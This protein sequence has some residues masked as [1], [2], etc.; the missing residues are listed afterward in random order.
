MKNKRKLILMVGLSTSALLI[1]SIAAVGLLKPA[2]VDIFSKA[3]DIYSCDLPSGY[4]EISDLMDYIYENATDSEIDN[5]YTIRGTITRRHD[6]FAFLQRVNQTTGYTDAIR[7]SGLN[8]LEINLKEGS[9]I[10]IQG[11]K[12]TLSYNTPTLY[13]SESGDTT[14]NVAF[15]TNPWGYEPKVY[16]GLNDYFSRGLASDTYNDNEEYAFSRYIK[17][18]G[19][20]PSFFED[21]ESY[22]IGDETYYIGGVLDPIYT[23]SL[24]NFAIKDNVGVS[25]KMS[26]A[27]SE[28]KLI[29][30]T[31][32][33]YHHSDYYLVLMQSSDDIT[34]SDKT[35]YDENVI[36]TR[37]S[38]K[39]IFG[40]ADSS[41][42]SFPSYLLKNKGDVPYVDFA[43][44]F[45]YRCAVFYSDYEY[46]VLDKYYLE[47]DYVV[48]SNQNSLG[49][50]HIDCN[51]D[52]ITVY[53]YSGYL[54]M[55]LYRLD[56]GSPYLDDR[57]DLAWCYPNEKSAGINH[58]DRIKTFDLG[59]FGLDIVMDKFGNAFVPITV[60]SNIFLTN[61]GYSFSFNGSNLYYVYRLLNDSDLLNLYWADSPFND[62]NRSEE[63]SAFTY[64]D[65]CFTLK[66]CYGLF[67]ERYPDG[68]P[69]ELIQS[70]GLKD[71]LTSTN[72]DELEEGLLKLT[73][74]WIFEGHAGYSALSPLTHSEDF[75]MEVINQIY[76]EALATNSRYNQLMETN[77]EL[78]SYRDEFGKQ[79]GLE[80]SGDTAIIRFDGFV[81]YDNGDTNTIDVDSYTY[82]QIHDMGS[83]LLFKKAFKEIGENPDID[84]VIIDLSL[85]GG[86]HIAV[87]PWLLAYLT[88]DV[89][90]AFRNITYGEETDLH[91][92]VDLN[93]DGVYDEL[94]TYKGKYNYYC[95][96]SR[97]SFSCGNWLPTVIH[98]KG[99]A[100]MIG[101]RSGGGIC[102]VSN[103]S[104]AVGTVFR[105][106]SLNQMGVYDGNNF[107][108]YED[109]SEVDYQIDR[110][111]FYDTAYLINFIHNLSN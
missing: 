95:L 110:Q 83:E 18:N 72:N 70:L 87:V 81:K 33:M 90:V 29:N 73:G 104:S 66:Y 86:G 74:Q 43:E 67:D 78:A 101:E 42:L 111:H 14:Y 51:A 65:L 3:Q 76:N 55:D 41:Q 11:G 20:K 68:N 23:S 59:Q 102:S 5:P 40:T 6:D 24:L 8:N 64:N 47:D 26:T 60:L 39:F 53:D 35:S 15:E 98:E 85:N 16:E 89:S 71:L 34:I 21:E 108:N 58:P 28:G 77:A 7:I 80:M 31:G 82:A 45:L 9:V 52:T 57:I 93:F 50:V 96:T 75:S 62:L 54:T 91:Y 49:E 1:S 36:A 12:I 100:T 22:S 37:T 92:N 30:I 79:I 32:I 13:M 97:A 10:D 94:D 19:V 84:N 44:F 88:D 61:F 56:D 2:G 27:I 4:H 109:G 69:D 106:S 107:I 63:Y 38:S 17:I 105:N 48:Y 25:D 99:L 103:M 46:F